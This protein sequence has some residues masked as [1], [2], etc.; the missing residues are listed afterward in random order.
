MGLDNDLWEDTFLCLAATL[1]SQKE[2]VQ[3]RPSVVST[4][5]PAETTLS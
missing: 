4:P 5:L 2:V 3:A 1:N